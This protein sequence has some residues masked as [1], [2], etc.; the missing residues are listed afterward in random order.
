MLLEN[1]ETGP[2]IELDPSR[3]S[4]ISD[5]RVRVRISVRVR[6]ESEWFGF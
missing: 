2:D 1:L 4:D 3:G 5:I 6:V